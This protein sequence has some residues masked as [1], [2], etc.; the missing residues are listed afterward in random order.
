M[1]NRKVVWTLALILLGVVPGSVAQGQGTSKATA[2]APTPEAFLIASQAIMPSGGSVMIETPC[3]PPAPPHLT[4][5][6]L[7]RLTDVR[8]QHRIATASKQAELQALMHKMGELL[9]Q[10]QIDRQGVKSLHGKIDSIRS[11]LSQARLT[12]ILDTAEVFSPEQRKEFHR[13]MLT[14]QARLPGMPF[15]FGDHDFLFSFPA[16]P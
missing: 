5:E 13:R 7:S 2:S 4:D 1:K 6:Q 16:P 3:S 15:A 9:S 8:D 12:M 10:P 11:D 14:Q